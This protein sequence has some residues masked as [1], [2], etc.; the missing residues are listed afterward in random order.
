MLRVPSLQILYFVTSGYELI[1]VKN[2]I[3][4]IFSDLL[5]VDIS[6]SNRLVNYGFRT[7]KDRKRQKGITW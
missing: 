4:D 1:Q 2:E 6:V 5:P 3:K 7:S